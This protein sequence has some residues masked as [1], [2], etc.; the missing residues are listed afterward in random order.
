MRHFLG[1]RSAIY[2]VKD[3]AAAKDWYIRVTGAPP[4]FDEPYY[5]GFSVGGYE[6][7]LLPEESAAGDRQPGGVAYWG[8][9]DA[10]AAYDR[11]LGLGAASFEPI[12]DH[13]VKIGAVRDPFGNIFGVIENPAFKAEAD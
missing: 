6:L 10:Q 4:Y 8:V 5:V 13:G 1:L 7:G 3:L 9:T 12:E 11:L 2:R